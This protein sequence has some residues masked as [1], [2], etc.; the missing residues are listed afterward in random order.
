MPPSLLHR[1]LTT[2][3]W[4]SRYRHLLPL[5]SIAFEYSNFDTQLMQNPDISGIEYQRGTLQ[6]YE[7]RNYLYEKY[8]RKCVYCD[9][10][11][12][13]MELDHI[14]P[15]SKGGSDRVSNLAPCCHKCNL[16]KGNML[17]D[18]FLKD[19]P[20]R[21]EKIKNQMKAPLKDATAMN[22]VRPAIL[23][24]LNRTGLT[25]TCWSGARTKWNR[26]RLSIPKD[27]HLDASCVGDIIAVHGWE[28]QDVLMIEAS[29][30]GSRKRKHVNQY[31]FP[32]GKPFMKQKSVNGFQSGDVVKATVSVGKNEGVH[33]GKVSVRST[34]RFNIKTEEGTIQGISWKNCTILQRKDGYTYQIAVQDR[35]HPTDKSD[36]FP[37]EVL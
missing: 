17:I 26:D 24:K 28:N 19:D 33:I 21:L 8:G 16:E 6:G 34:G 11:V 36:G 13:R 23:R 12:D 20:E 32:Y 27:H 14:V 37:A 15:R 18:E 5:S 30:H 3:T 31:G 29:G 25:V 7:V 2:E 35:I 22:V 9:A 1:V 4:V 10:E